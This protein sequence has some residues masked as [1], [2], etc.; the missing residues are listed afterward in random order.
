M[1]DRLDDTLVEFITGQP[2]F[3]VA[4]APDGPHGHVNLSPKGLDSF[5]VL[6]DRTVGYLDLTGSGVETIAHLRQNGRLTFMFCAFE[7]PPRILRLYGRGSVHLVGSDR[8]AQLSPDFAEIEGVRSIITCDLER[9]Q[10]SCGYAV[11]LMDLTG[12]RPTLI[13]WAERHGQDG[14]IDYWNERNRASIDG[15]PGHPGT[16]S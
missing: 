4:S 13:E 3:F 15:L 11:P 8:F 7:G 5:R 16:R 10:T 12:Q 6:A 14:L 1:H 9:I 2:V